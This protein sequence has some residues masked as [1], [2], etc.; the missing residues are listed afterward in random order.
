MEYNVTLNSAIDF[1]P[2]SR[3]AEILQNVRTILNTR[4]GSAPLARD[5]GIT[6]EHVDKPLPVAQSIMQ[7]VVID[8]IEEFEPR[9]KVERVAFDGDGAEGILRPSVIIS[10]TEV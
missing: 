5:L 7:G 2:E 8:A 4:L 10:I 3:T 9:A 6:W 1:A